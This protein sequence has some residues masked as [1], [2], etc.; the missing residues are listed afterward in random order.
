M[1]KSRRP[2]YALIPHTRQLVLAATLMHPHRWWYLS[3]LAK[4]VGVAPSSLQREVA[5]LVDAGVLKRKREGNRVYY[6]AERDN[7][8]YPEL[9]G[10]L[11][12]TAGLM[13]V[14]RDALKRFVPGIVAAF[15]YGSVARSEEGARSDIDLMVVGDVGLADL[16]PALRQAEV[17]LGRE[18]TV[19][20]YP[21]QELVSKAKARQHFVRDVL[22]REKLFVYGSASELEAIVGERQRTAAP[23]GQDRA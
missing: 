2:L 10:L 12:K 8:F 16:A 20:L 5:G 15:V 1:R 17:R 7:P 19:V 9:R 13:D 14:L 6:Q 4:H 22:S 3:D 21:V 18:V 11:L 23:G